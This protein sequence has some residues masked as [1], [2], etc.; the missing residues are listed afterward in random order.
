MLRRYKVKG[1]A[2]RE[3]DARWWR[4]EAAKDAA[5]KTKLMAQLM[6]DRRA[7]A[8]KEFNGR[9]RLIKTSIP[10]FKHQIGL[11]EWK[12]LNSEAKEKTGD[13]WFVEYQNF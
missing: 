9:I 4:E 13:S 2:L 11:K 6:E 1:A 10:G 7:A 12:F 8:L 3:A 5:R